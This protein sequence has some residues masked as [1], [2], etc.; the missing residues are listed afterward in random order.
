VDLTW[1]HWRPCLKP[2]S[3]NI[4]TLSPI[5]LSPR[6]SKAF[7]VVRTPPVVSPPQ[8]ASPAWQPGSLLALHAK[9]LWNLRSTLRGSRGHQCQNRRYS[10][11]VRDLL[12]KPSRDKPHI[13]APIGY[14]GELNTWRQAIPESPPHEAVVESQPLVLARYAASHFVIRGTRKESVFTRR[15]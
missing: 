3:Q 12:L 9:P 4:P 2:P 13:H 11:C 8:S 10:A 15:T 6:L 1:N 7:A 5:T 14:V